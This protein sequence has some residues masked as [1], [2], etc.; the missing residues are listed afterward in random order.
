[1]AP[2]SIRDAFVDI[3][4]SRGFNAEEVEQQVFKTSNSDM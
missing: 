4:S 3:Y 2:A 1:M